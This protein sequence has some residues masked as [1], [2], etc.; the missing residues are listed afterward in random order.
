[1]RE[2]FLQV[3]SSVP[4]SL[5]HSHPHRA[6][7]VAGAFYMREVGMSHSVKEQILR[8]FPNSQKS[9]GNWACANSVYHT[10]FPPPMHESLGKRLS[11]DIA[12]CVFTL[13]SKHVSSSLSHRL[14]CKKKNN[15]QSG[16]ENAQSAARNPDLQTEMALLGHRN[17]P[18]VC[19]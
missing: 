15:Q 3:K 8:K 11:A 1:M 10:F 12:D 16:Y 17:L 13:S 9:R 18:S 5:L 4:S 19:I 2:Q 7:S 6:W 14:L